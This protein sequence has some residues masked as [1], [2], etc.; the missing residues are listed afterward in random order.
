MSVMRPVLS[1]DAEA[2]RCP[3]PHY[4]QLRNSGPVVYDADLNIYIVAHHAN[5]VQVNTKPSIFSN[6]NP[7][8]P[9]ITEAIERLGRVLASKD[10]A[11]QQRAATVLRRGDVLFTADPPEHSRHR[12]ILNKAMTPSAVRNIEPVIESYCNELLNGFDTKSVIDIVNSY[13]I[14][15]PIYSLATLLGVPIEMADDFYRWATAINATIGT[16]LN[17]DQLLSAIEDQVSFWDYF[18]LQLE[19]RRNEPGNDLLSAV[20]HGRSGDD[21]PLTL[22]EMVGFCSQLVAAGSDTTTKLIATAVLMLC[23]DP[24]LAKGLREDPSLIPG[25]LEEALRLE[26][27][28]QGMFRVATEAF[29]LES[30]TIPKDALV[31]VLYA[32]ANRDE[33]VFECP[34]RMQPD[35]KNLKA[36]MSFGHGPHTCIGAT[37]ARSVARIAITALLE[38]FSTINL[39]DPDFVPEYEASYIMRGM[40]ALPARLTRAE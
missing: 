25:F 19:A 11:F 13:A 32:S 28:V 40:T 18:E 14:P 17:D 39:A 20:V 16:S 10:A 34:N 3:Y 22:N 4:E 30:V 24:K 29:D 36:H 26:P 37:L 33:Q 23:R 21:Q 7:M 2:L 38:R 1:L 35:R 9:A 6:S 12:R 31:W 27:P 5:I 8:G 15:A